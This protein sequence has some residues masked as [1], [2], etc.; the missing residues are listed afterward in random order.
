MALGA[1]ASCTLNCG[2]VCCYIMADMAAYGVLIE[3]GNIGPI[4]DLLKDMGQDPADYVERVQW[5][6]IPEGER[7][8]IELAHNLDD[9]LFM[10]DGTDYVYHTLINEDWPIPVGLLH[11]APPTVDNKKMWVGPYSLA[12]MFLNG[13][14]SCLLYQFSDKGNDL[15]PGV[16]RRFLCMLGY[17]IHLLI[18][19]E[20][21]ESY[22]V[23][24]KNIFELYKI[25]ETCLVTLHDNMRHEGSLDK[26][27]IEREMAL[28]DAVDSYLKNKTDVKEKLKEFRLANE[29]YVNC[30]NKIRNEIH[31]KFI[32]MKLIK[33]NP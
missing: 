9:Y 25:S 14:N 19:L 10:E 6:N 5:D 3:S 28:R 33:T 26:M 32:D 22:F 17:I 16:C 23:E 13:D 31:D 27:E 21:L 20:L 8:I 2:S 15:R 4:K 1:G 18:R 24:N 12:C 11:M 29:G 7:S 30:T